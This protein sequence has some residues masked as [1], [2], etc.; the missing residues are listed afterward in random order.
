MAQAGLNPDAPMF[1][2]AA[3]RR[4]EDY[5]PQWWELVNS[6]AWFRNHALQNPQEH[7]V[8][9]KV[10]EDEHDDIAALLPDDLLHD[11]ADL[12]LYSPPPLPPQPQHQPDLLHRYGPAAGFGGHGIDA[13]ALRAQLS[14]VNSPRDTQPSWHAQKPAQQ[15]LVG[16][17]N[18]Q[19]R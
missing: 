5:S 13:V 15:Q 9:A 1:I 11:A 12:F 4:V 17:G 10:E 6:T 19:W 14:V 8:E 3:F 7:R 16:G 18:R 2:P